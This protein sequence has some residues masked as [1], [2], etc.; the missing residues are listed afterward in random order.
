VAQAISDV[1]PDGDKDKQ[2][3]QGFL[4]GRESYRKD[5]NYQRKLFEEG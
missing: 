4:Y 2:M 5:Y 3:L 1:L